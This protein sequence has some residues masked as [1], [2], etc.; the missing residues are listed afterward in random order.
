MV[1]AVG[2]IAESRT[3]EHP[4]QAAAAATGLG[5]VLGLCLAHLMAL[6]TR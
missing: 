5:L 6:M 1:R 4:S 2:R 3:R